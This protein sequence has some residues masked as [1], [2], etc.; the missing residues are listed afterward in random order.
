VAREIASGVRL[1]T[2]SP[3]AGKAPAASAPALTRH[4]AFWPALLVTGWLVQ[5]MV[6]LLLVAR[7]TAPV[8]I[9]DES[10]YLLGARA[11]SGGAAGD[12]SGRTFYQA[13]Y[14][15]LVAPA[16]WLS[17]D[18]VTV[19]HLVLGMNA[20]VG[21]ALMPL[22][23][24]ALRRFDVPR[25]Y[26]YVLAGTAALLPAVL[27]YGQFALSD[28]VLPVVVLGWLL[29]VHSWIAGGRPVPAAAASLLAA[30]AYAA[31]PRGLVVVAAHAGLLVLVALR[32]CVPRRDTA[33]AGF[34]LIAAAVGAFALNGW[35][36][37]R[38]YPRGVAPLGDWLV[39]RLTSLSG[40]GWTASVAV[41][42]LWYLLVA[43]F[44]LGGVGLLAFGALLANRD[45]PRASRATACLVLVSVAGIALATSAALPDEG[46][47]ANL[48]YGRYLTCVA[49]VLFLAGMVFLRRAPRVWATRAVLA[50]AALAATSAAVVWL[51]A[52]D[53]LSQG[54]FG[55][56][57]F[58]EICALTGDWD[59]LRLRSAT[60]V[61]LALLALVLLLSTGLR[62]ERGLVVATAV[63]AALSLTVAIIFTGRVSR[64]WSRAL[65]GAT[66]LAPA[67]L[68]AG[69][70]VGVSYADLPWRIWV[71]QAVQ[72]RNG[73]RPVDRFG[74]FPLPADVTLV[75]TPWDPRLPVRTS[76]PAAPARWRPV[77]ANHG[78]LGGWAAWRRSP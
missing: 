17:D 71:S 56:F 62:H 24:V 31:H 7:Q 13:G 20:L 70:H 33:L 10:G 55:P 75:V 26:A 66:S 42:Q 58:P 28:A 53:R 47:V 23:Y 38:T 36:K 73:I 52:G 69:D 44:G 8:L 45:V 65:T 12:L 54:F 32:R 34:T 74:R 68:R 2:L 4:G 63:L 41:G 21:A 60:G 51:H 64:Y 77:L 50:S 61:A 59:S 57:D 5:V 18:A 14:S 1:R 78:Y 29:L 76:W 16:Y 40:L 67:G 43:T 39:D 46:T 6:R 49:P 11:L 30:Y 19:Y 15:L 22:A 9:P 25:P 35:V 37:A 3:I 27:Y 72:A 48:A